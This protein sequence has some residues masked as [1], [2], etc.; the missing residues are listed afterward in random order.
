MDIK[1]FKD[2]FEEIEELD[3]DEVDIT[4]FEDLVYELER[5]VQDAID[6]SFP[7][8]EKKLKKLMKKIIRFKEDNDF[9]DHNSELENMFPN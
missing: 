1:R 7:D 6:S 3:Y 5:D 4:E 9:F 2:R 8:D